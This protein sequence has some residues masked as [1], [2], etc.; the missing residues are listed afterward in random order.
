MVSVRRNKLYLCI[1]DVVMDWSSIVAYTKGKIYKSESSGKLTDNN[2]HRDHQIS[3]E[4]ATIHFVDVEEIFKSHIKNRP[5]IRSLKKLGLTFE[6]IL[7]QYT[8]YKLSQIEISS[9]KTDKIKI[10]FE[11][12]E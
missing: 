2:G 3:D 8:K 1:E 10:L 7:E 9:D 12:I 5:M 11:N 4:F 6:Q